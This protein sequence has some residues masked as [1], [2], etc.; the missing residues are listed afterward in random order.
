MEEADLL[1]ALP[2]LKNRRYAT[3]ATA[4]REAHAAGE[5]LLPMFPPP[6]LP[7]SAARRPLPST[8]A[9]PFLTRAVGSLPHGI[10]DDADELLGLYFSGATRKPPNLDVNF[11][12]IELSSMGAARRAIAAA[13]AADAPLWWATLHV[14]DLEHPPWWPRRAAVV[15]DFEQLI[16]GA[17]RSGI[18]MHRDRFVEGEKERL[19]STY[20]TLGRGIKH[21]VLLPPAA[22]A[23]AEELGGDSCDT[24]Y[25]RT[26]SQRREL[27]PSPPP[28]VLERVMEAGGFWFDLC[29]TTVPG[30]ASEGEEGAGS[31]DDSDEE[32][33]AALCMFIPAGWYHWLAADAAWH[34]A[35]SGSFFPEAES[36]GSDRPKPTG[37]RRRK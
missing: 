36:R 27:P 31:D 19:V 28:E 9:A 37:S 5:P 21:V 30:A 13:A 32:E 20:L 23:L 24:A 35:W 33:E 6:L 26:T 3:S 22:T 1:L 15:P 34:V 12:N 25:G 11:E 18:G 2:A 8:C 14:P 10:P 7:S 17:G 29:E 4:Y 16:V